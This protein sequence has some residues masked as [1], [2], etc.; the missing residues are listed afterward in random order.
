MQ[1]ADQ[2]WSHAT[3]LNNLYICSRFFLFKVYLC[4]HTQS[5]LKRSSSLLIL[6]LS[7]SKLLCNT[8]LSP[9]AHHHLLQHLRKP[10][11]LHHLSLTLFPLLH[12]L[13][14]AT[15]GCRVMDKPVAG[16]DQYLLLLL[17]YL[18]SCLEISHFLLN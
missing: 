18:P 6:S 17:Y 14:I 7:T 2:I 9:T 5:T 12:S 1:K 4:N 8:V 10:H 11:L 15:T 3:C 13:P 16:Q